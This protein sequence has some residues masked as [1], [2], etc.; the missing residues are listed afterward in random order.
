M[1]KNRFIFHELPDVHAEAGE[2][3]RKGLEKLTDAEDFGTAA[4][5][6]DVLRICDLQLWLLKAQNNRQQ[7]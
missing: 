3:T 2:Q 4:L 7:T 1:N 6:T 5:L